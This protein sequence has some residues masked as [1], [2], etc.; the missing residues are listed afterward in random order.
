M[1]RLALVILFVCLSAVLINNQVDAFFKAGRSLHDR[2]AARQVDNAMEGEIGA[3]DAKELWEEFVK[4]RSAE[5]KR[6]M[7]DR[8]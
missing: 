2:Q 8:Q 6:A 1:N 7:Q 4:A 3:A 5:R